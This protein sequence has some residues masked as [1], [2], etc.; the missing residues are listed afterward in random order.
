[1]PKEIRSDSNLELNKFLLRY[2]ESENSRLKSELK[3][4]YVLWTVRIY[5]KFT[6]NRYILRTSEK[7]SKFLNFIYLILNKKSSYLIRDK[8]DVIETS[9]VN[10]NV[11]EELKL[12]DFT[13]IF[14]L[15]GHEA[16]LT[17]APVVLLE[18][19]KQLKKDH[20]VLFFLNKDG[21]M[22]EDYMRISNTKVLKN[23]TL[24]IDEQNNFKDF[25]SN[26]NQNN[27]KYKII[28]NTVA[29]NFWVDFLIKNK[30][31][32]ITW[33]HELNTSWNF[34][35]TTFENQINYS[36]TIIADSQLIKY[37]IEQRFGD[38]LNI[39]F[40]KNGDSIN[41]KQSPEE[42]RSFLSIEDKKL[43]LLAGTRSIRKGFDLLP[44]LGV[45]LNKHKNLKNNYKVLWI[46]SSMNPEL[47]MFVL[48]DIERFGLSENI[49]IMDTVNNYA[50][51]LNSCD[52]FIHLARED[53]APQVVENAI[54]LDKPIVMFEGIGGRKLDDSDDKVKVSKYLDLEDFISKLN[55][56]SN[57]ERKALLPGNYSSWPEQAKKIIDIVNSVNKNHQQLLAIGSPV[58][59]VQEVVEE[60][61][62]QMSLSVIIPN[63]NHE[64]FI[65]ERIR[66]VV[67]QKVSPK[68][69]I[70]LDDASE[71]KSLKIAREEL[72]KTLIPTKILV[73]TNNSGNVLNQWRKG[74]NEASSEWV[75]I[76]ESDDSSSLD[77][78]QSAQQIIQANNSDL[79]IFESKIIDQNSNT[80]FENSHFNR[81]H[82]PT[83]MNEV[84][85][86]GSIT[87]SMNQLK[88][89]G[90]L[91]RN[92][93]VNVS[94]LL[95]KK[96]YLLEAINRTI[97]K[98]PPNIVGDWT[99]YL[100]LPEDIKVTY[101]DKSLNYFRRTN[102]GVRAKVDLNKEIVGARN[103]ILSNFQGMYSREDK[104]RFKLENIRIE[105]I[106]GE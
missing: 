9:N 59:Q 7:V 52:I 73:N 41:I 32:Y 27:V 97:A 26:L 49:E 81:I 76:A 62:A 16:S 74:I 42:I 47:D 43:I 25:L 11:Y 21:P 53:S 5:F 67:E 78:I 60:A 93:I 1:M 37:Q 91:I 92:L 88:K 65:V 70:L 17:G 38:K 77:F 50:D 55:E 95:C 64:N 105:K 31:N 30:I 83:V 36:E 29:Q 71:D 28:L 8:T 24:T 90:F 96:E 85:R 10:K 19:A 35:P 82:V 103:F 80:L 98:N 15:I 106:Y 86:G 14:I 44:K 79:V 33:I 102:D 40:V 23:E 48:D 39:H 54:R 2:F 72:H 75:W 68:E 4:L 66:T 51:Y 18:L 100:E 87:I 63:Y 104:L 99:C 94:A 13:S 89:D 69:I 22:T 61:Y 84:E 3:S 57:K 6:K 34:W 45:E 20:E 12:K 58:Q 101:C 56:I 46:G